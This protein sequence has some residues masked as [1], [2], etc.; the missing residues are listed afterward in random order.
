MTANVAMRRANNRPLEP[1]ILG[2][3]GKCLDMGIAMQPYFDSDFHIWS[4]NSRCGNVAAR[5]TSRY[6]SGIPL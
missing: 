1:L 3:I 2:Y 6:A 5:P 4:Q